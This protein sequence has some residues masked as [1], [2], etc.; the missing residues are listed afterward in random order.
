MKV[1]LDVNVWVSGLL[2]RGRP[3]LILDLSKKQQI[4][5]FVSD[6]LRQELENTLRRTKFKS[7]IQSLAITVE[8]LLT[9]I[10]ELSQ[11]SPYLSVELPELRDLDDLVI[12]GTAQAS[13]A[14]FIITGDQDLLVLKKF[15]DIPILTPQDFL[16]MFGV[17][18]LQ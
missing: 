7:K 2:W 11:S 12:L 1:V 13:Q 16:K 5:I 10:K 3:G 17:E 4:T 8:D 6:G 18:K 9:V 15:N 14:E